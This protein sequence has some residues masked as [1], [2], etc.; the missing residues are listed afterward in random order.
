MGAK[1]IDEWEYHPFQSDHMRLNLSTAESSVEFQ[2]NVLLV[3]GFL[4]D[5]VDTV[6]DVKV[7]SGATPV[8]LDSIY[9]SWQDFFAASPPS[10]PC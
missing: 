5:K 7:P 2:S 3:K 9:E 10:R 1:F 8:Q 4:L 6:C